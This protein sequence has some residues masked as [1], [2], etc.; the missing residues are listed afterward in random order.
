MAAGTLI[1]YRKGKVAPEEFGVQMERLELR[2]K[3]TRWSGGRDLR[4]QE[5]SSCWQMT[6]NPSGWWTTFVASS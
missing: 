3:E 2:S 5:A 4:Q 1:F 6:P